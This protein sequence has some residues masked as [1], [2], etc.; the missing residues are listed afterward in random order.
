VSEGF[1]VLNRQYYRDN[2]ESNL[3]CFIYARMLPTRPARTVAVA[4]SSAPVGARDLLVPLVVFT[5][6]CEL[7]VPLV[8]AAP[9]VA[10]VPPVDALDDTPPAFDCT[11]APGPADA[12]LDA[13]P[14]PALPDA[15][16]LPLPV[17][18]AADEDAFAPLS[19]PADAPLPALADAPSP[20]AAAAE[21]VDADVASPDPAELPAPDPA[22]A[23][24]PLT[25]AAA[26]DEAA[27]DA[28]LSELWVV[29]T[30][31]VD[32][33]GVVVEDVSPDAAAAAAAPPLAAAAAGVPS[34]ELATATDDVE[35]ELELDA[36][37]DCSTMPP[38]ELISLDA[39][40]AADELELDDALALPAAIAGAA[41][42]ITAIIPIIAINDLVIVTSMV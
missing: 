9:L 13:P 36:S 2:I 17:F 42:V 25:A 14:L 35:L 27:D 40:E 30:G 29:V 39:D 33:T 26:A 28:A 21:L 41:I 5:A 31:V 15:A 16:A 10:A 18:A 4:T 20:A 34:S 32:S 11:C 8:A 24:A 1:I 6:T 3:R 12:E 37:V 19:P 7:G 23:A 38:S 22:A